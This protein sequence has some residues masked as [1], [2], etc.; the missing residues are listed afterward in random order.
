MFQTLSLYELIKILFFYTFDVSLEFEIV[1]QNQLYQAFRSGSRSCTRNPFH[2]ACKSD[3]Q[4]I[5]SQNLVKWHMR[6]LVER[7]VSKSG[8]DVRYLNELHIVTS[9]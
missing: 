5:I 9:F 7:G 3:S 1:H 2:H 6:V 8:L 4:K